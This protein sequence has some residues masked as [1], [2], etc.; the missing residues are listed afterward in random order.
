MVIVIVE[1]LFIVWH[2]ALCT[3]VIVVKLPATKEGVQI[4]EKV[5]I[6]WCEIWAMLQA[7]ILFPSKGYEETLRCRGSVWVG[8]V[9]N[10]H[11]APCKHLTLVT[12]DCMMQFFKRFVI[13]LSWLWRF[14]ASSPQAKLLFCSKTMCMIY[15][16]ENVCLIVFFVGDEVCHHSKDFCFDS[17]L[18]MTPMSHS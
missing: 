13:Y 14:E 7:I 12:L 9:M 2:Q 5:I 11:S 16:E 15:W 1:A 6:A 18:L 17:G 8:I 10:Q 3:F 4:L